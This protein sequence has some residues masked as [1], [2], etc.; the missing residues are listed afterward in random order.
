MRTLQFSRDLVDHNFL[1]DLL[2]FYFLIGLTAHHDV[3]LTENRIYRQPNNSGASGEAFVKKSDE[4]R[5]I[6]S[7]IIFPARLHDVQW[8]PL[9]VVVM[10]RSVE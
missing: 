8:Q 5:I 2:A 1:V 6:F 3:V 9:L 10:M 7:A 4:N